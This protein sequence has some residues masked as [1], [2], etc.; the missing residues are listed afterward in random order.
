M[1]S[2]ITKYLST[3]WTYTFRINH[4][5]RVIDFQLHRHFHR[6]LKSMLDIDFE[7]NIFGAYTG[8]QYDVEKMAILFCRVMALESQLETSTYVIWCPSESWT[9]PVPW[10]LQNTRVSTT[11]Y[12]CAH[13]KTIIKIAK[14]K[15]W[16]KAWG[17]NVLLTTSMNYNLV[18]KKFL[19][20]FL[21]IFCLFH[22]QKIKWTFENRISHRN[23]GH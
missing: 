23:L 21:F 4:N 8:F 15:Q 11:S 16:K 13:R 6:V 19:N 9:F 18:F 20:P 17:S 22:P 2:Q 1:H 3:Y 12:I 7:K 5:P 14:M 10:L